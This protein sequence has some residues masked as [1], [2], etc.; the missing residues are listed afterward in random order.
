MSREQVEVRG[1]VRP[2]GTLLLDERLP[3]PPGPVAVVVRPTAEPQTPPEDWW[4]YLRRTR[5]QLEEAGHA[6]L[7]DEEMKAHV[8]WLREGDCIDELLRRAD[9]EHRRPERP[10]C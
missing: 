7:N 8:E 4:Q 3:L 1:T 2:D 10:E 5:L 6:F 9:E